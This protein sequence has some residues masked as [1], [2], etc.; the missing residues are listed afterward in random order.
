MV[1]ISTCHS[2]KG[3]EWPVVFIPA[4]MKG[5]HLFNGKETHL[6]SLV[7]KNVFPFYRSDDEGEER[8]LDY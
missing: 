6:S 8:Y 7:E 1:T 5:Q 4:G 3:L 2:A